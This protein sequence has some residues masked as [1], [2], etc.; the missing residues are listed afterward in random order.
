MKV[1]TLDMSIEYEHVER[2][3]K[4]MGML[5]TVPKKSLKLKQ[6]PPVR[7]SKQWKCCY[8]ALKQK[9]V[10]HLTKLTPVHSVEYM[11]DEELPEDIAAMLQERIGKY[12]TSHFTD[13]QPF[14]FK[15]VEESVEEQNHRICSSV[16]KCLYSDNLN[17]RAKWLDH[18]GRTHGLR[19]LVDAL[20]LSSEL[21]STEAPMF[22]QMIS[23][24]YNYDTVNAATVVK[25]NRDHAQMASVAYGPELTMLQM[26]FEVFALTNGLAIN[27]PASKWTSYDATHY[28]ELHGCC[29][30]TWEQNKFSRIG[31]Y[32]GK[33]LL[34]T[35]SG[36]LIVHLE[37]TIAA[38]RLGDVRQT[39][40]AQ[41]LGKIS[42]IAHQLIV[43]VACSKLGELSLQ[44]N[45]ILDTT[46]GESKTWEEYD[47]NVISAGSVVI[48]SLGDFRIN[49]WTKRME[50]GTWPKDH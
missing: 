1:Y 20:L 19:E 17:D 49:D 26:N 45:E 8:P 11:V 13:P 32:G 14:Y 47:V 48:K 12:G 6:T 5:K 29:P 30:R 31:T 46:I 15:V 23:Y 28:P 40:N 7:H 44:V 3:L 36:L 50:N 34:A 41:V 10:R 37:P 39:D 9:V 35:P 43:D 38:T 4:A 27:L 33:P 22:Q 16:M 42:S 2:L 21:F 25:R 24:L 18:D